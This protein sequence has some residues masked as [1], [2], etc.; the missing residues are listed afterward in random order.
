MCVCAFSLATKHAAE[1]Q[2]QRY[3]TRTHHEVYAIPLNTPRA[4]CKNK[5]CSTIFEATHPSI[6]CATSSLFVLI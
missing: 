5:K 3:L 4:S 2:Q 1:L 6:D